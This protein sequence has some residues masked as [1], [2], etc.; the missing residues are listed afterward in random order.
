MFFSSNRY[1]SGAG[2]G[3]EL[4]NDGLLACN[5]QVATSQQ[6]VSWCGFL[7]AG[8]FFVVGFY[9]ANSNNFQ[10]TARNAFSV[11]LVQQTI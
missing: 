11:A 5:V 6:N 7:A 8:D 9:S 2:G 10:N 3:N 1:G 4:N